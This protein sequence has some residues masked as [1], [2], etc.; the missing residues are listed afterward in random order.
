MTME[1]L[2]LSW[3]KFYHVKEGWEPY[4]TATGVERRLW[5]ASQELVLNR[6]Q[7]SK[8]HLSKPTFHC[9]WILLHF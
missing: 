4:D 1:G 8:N 6:P 9:L 7:S 5:T 2:E 3:N